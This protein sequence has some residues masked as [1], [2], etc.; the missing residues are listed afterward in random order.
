M[1][2]ESHFQSMLVKEIH[3]QYPGA[4]VLK[5]DP[6]YIQG[7]PDLII[8]NEYNWAALEVKRQEYS[9]YQA[10][11]RYWVEYLNDMS[12]ASFVYPENIREVLRG[13]QQTLH[14]SRPARLP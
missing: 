5:T 11:Q 8:L 3:K 4:V 1:S 9:P 12:Y 14:V 13:L 10:N 2:R 7:F 6:N